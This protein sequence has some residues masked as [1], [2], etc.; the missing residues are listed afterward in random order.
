MQKRTSQ[1]ENETYNLFEDDYTEDFDLKSANMFAI[2]KDLKIEFN[3]E[4][5]SLLKN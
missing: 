5:A 1:K 3:F 4:I 2:F